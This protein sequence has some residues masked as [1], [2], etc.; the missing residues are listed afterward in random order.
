VIARVRLVLRDLTA[1]LGA[2]GRALVVS[3]A[4]V[5]HALLRVALDEPA[6]SSLGVAF[7]PASIMRLR[8]DG[9]IPWRL[10]RVNE[11]ARPQA[12]PATAAQ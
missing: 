5:M 3:H 8:G 12:D 10:E 11:M 7:L 9:R 4:G 2:K 6:E 1:R